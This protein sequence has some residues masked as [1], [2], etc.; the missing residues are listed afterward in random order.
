MSESID[1]RTRAPRGV[2]A[3][4]ADV[5]QQFSILFSRVRGGMR[6]N[7]ARFH[8][9]L[10][11]LGYGIVSVLSQ[12]ESMRPGEIARELN[13]DKGAMSRQAAELERLGL[14]E[15]AADPDDHRSVRLRLTPAAAA[16]M[17]AERGRRR[18]LG[19]EQLSRWELADLR[20]LA[21]L[22]GRVN[23][24]VPDRPSSP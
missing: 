18:S 3:A 5:E 10:G 6:E 14:V 24:I 19:Y 22:L 11:V 2:D 9:E 20:R 4:I 23:E 16:R 13:L 15:R 7:A 8:P 1:R 21:E 12:A 17:L